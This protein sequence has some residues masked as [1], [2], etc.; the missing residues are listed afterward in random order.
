[1]TRENNKIYNLLYSG[2]I[3]FICLMWII[4]GEKFVTLLSQQHHTILYAFISG[5]LLSLIL[6][7]FYRF[8]KV[9]L[10]HNEIL[11]DDNSLHQIILENISHEEHTGLYFKDNQ[12]RYLLINETAE[13]LLQLVGREINGK[14][15]SQLFDSITGHKMQQED[16]RVLE[17]GMAISW[18]I[19][20][21]TGHGNDYW[22]GKKIPCFDKRGKQIGLIGLFNNSTIL[23]TF[24]NMNVELDERYSNLF[25][26]L[27]YP[28]IVL[29]PV[30]LMPHTFNQAI[31]DLLAYSSNDFRNTRFS[32]HIASQLDEFMKT[33]KYLLSQGGGEFAL[34]LKDRNHNLIQ[35]SSY[36]QKIV[37]EN[38]PYL[39][40][41][42]HDVTEL[43]QNT[44]EL[45]SSELKYRSLFEYAN[46]AILVVDIQTLTITD[47]NEIGLKMFGYRRDDFITMSIFDL[48]NQASHE[49]LR[50]QINNLE[51]YNHALFTHCM[52][53]RTGL[54]IDI[55]IN[56]HK[57][58]YGGQQ[59][60]QFVIRDISQRRQTEHALQESE[61]RYRQMFENNQAS[62]LVIDT[63]KHLIVDANP[64]AAS[65]Y[66]YSR[67]NMQGMSLNQVN[68]LSI[69]ELDEKNQH[70][71]TDGNVSYTCPHRLANGTV[72][73]VEVHNT[74]MVI[75]QKNLTFS[76]IN[77]VTDIKKIQDKLLLTTKSLENVREG[78]V[79]TDA[80]QN[81]ISCNQSFSEITGHA[82]D[83]LENSSLSQIMA[84]TDEA[85]INPAIQ[86]ELKKNESWQG[87]L[88]VR[89]PI[90]E[91]RAVHTRI[92]CVTEE[93]NIKNYI[94]S[95]MPGSLARNGN[96]AYSHI[97]TLTSLPGQDIYVDRLT[98]AIERAKRSQKAMAIILIN[99]KGFA[100]INQSYSFD[101][102]DRIL[103]AISL[104]LRSNIRES[105]T[106]SHFHSDQFA[107]LL[108]DMQ[109]ADD[110]DTV[111]Q[112]I[113][114]TLTETL[115]VDS[116]RISLDYAL[117]ISQYPEHGASADE[118]IKAAEHAQVFSQQ[119]EAT[120]YIIHD[121]Q[122]LH[123]RDIPESLPE[124]RLVEALKNHE[125]KI[126]YLPIVN[127]EDMSIYGIESL[128]RWERDSTHIMHPDGF[129]TIAEQTGFIEV[130]GYK[131][132]DQVFEDLGTL[133]HNKLNIENININLV[134]QQLDQELIS[135]LEQQCKNYNLAPQNLI[136]DFK[137]QDLVTLS[138]DKS[139]Y[140]NQLK[141]LGFKVC[142]DDF[143]RR[144]AS[145]TWLI[146]CPV[147]VIKIDYTLIARM[148]R[149][150][151]V[152]TLLSGLTT[153]AE[154]M[155][156][157]VIAEG[158]ESESQFNRLQQL[159]CHYMQGSYFN[160]MANLETLIQHNKQR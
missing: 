56:A 148:D 27:P 47:I 135:Y 103:K 64:A 132:I 17:T 83:Q 142:I 78:L 152:L 14:K 160:N 8:I 21:N 18:E 139:D 57:V 37:L 49:N 122:Q 15:D 85:F 65:F 5:I 10:I 12:G 94:I 109:V 35:V 2:F 51:I 73:I 133:R 13:Q 24:Q 81:I 97:S 76:I 42:L 60:Y 72:R 61:Q 105:D 99:I 82:L 22:I 134:L 91:T 114:T 19:E 44:E 112:K 62:M 147:N 67:D 23:K 137:E 120:R 157:Q 87:E 113:L 74:D 88:W 75:N 84:A 6:A 69:K 106:A 68:L 39:H 128:L 58:N 131:L 4:A 79:I 145:L 111:A 1:M 54:A 38:Q 80:D 20:K 116:H 153:L 150:D 125:F 9:L 31:C 110:I 28:V 151:N 101:F 102:G 36:G 52:R 136:L 127:T 129:L 77:D 48:D 41:L 156:V 104:R 108:E 30:S 71:N 117:G 149:D 7:A 123:N 66:G 130:L 100:K 119:Q 86:Q 143:G 98:N 90:G 26:K 16:Q 89:S 159:G 53:N 33:I 55:E 45:I 93:D 124:H 115:V 107:V 34:E 118:I 43:Q 95:I 96:T 25:N 140:L 63:R 29:D 32:S 46:D 70:G 138:R 59:V 126:E 146:K 155:N 40:I 92:G 50:N 141:H 3:L 121:H 158:V 11:L 154:K 144:N